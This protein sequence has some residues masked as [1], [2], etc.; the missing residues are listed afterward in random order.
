MHASL[1]TQP[2]TL[3]EIEKKLTQAKNLIA[4]KSNTDTERF[5]GRLALRVNEF[6]TALNDKTL[7]ELDKE[8]ILS[9]Y[10][11]FA[12]TLYK[13]LHHPES[14]PIYTSIYFNHRYHPVSVHQ[15]STLDSIKYYGSITATTLGA[16]LILASLASFLFNPMLATV[17]LPIGITLLAPSL[18]SLCLAETPDLS[19]KKREEQL[20][21]DEGIKLKMQQIEQNDDDVANHEIP[22]IV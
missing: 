2:P 3:Q 19:G 1:F 14:G 8:E 9:Q 16:A 6:T 21:F 20:I 13:C 18:F 15:H 4:D 11:R 10:Y 22:I 7:S 5:L 12:Q 17:L